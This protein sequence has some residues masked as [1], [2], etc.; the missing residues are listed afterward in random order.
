MNEQL[1]TLES[2][3]GFL[4][5]LA[6]EG[7]SATLIGGSILIAAGVTFGLASVA[8]WAAVSGFL[9]MLSGWIHLIIWSASMVAFLIELFFLRR[10][11]GPHKAGGAVNRA[12]GVAWSGAG[13][14]MFTLF[15]SAYVISLR[16][17]S[18]G[19]LM[20]LPSVVLAIYGLCWTVAA[21]ATRKTWVRAAAIG[22]FVGAVIVAAMPGEKADYLVFALALALLAVLPGA[23]LVRQ[24]K[25][26]S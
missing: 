20:M 1:S 16:T 6:T 18:D 9:P 19:A 21:E 11:L 22:S 17:D 25:A 26:A 8:V 7:R 2:D 13:F 4:K 15:V 3:I 10:R 5:A 12:V 14:A 24:A 23:V